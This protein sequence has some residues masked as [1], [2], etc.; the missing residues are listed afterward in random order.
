[1]QVD[2]AT[3]ATNKTGSF[4]YAELGIRTSRLILLVPKYSTGAASVDKNTSYSSASRII[5]PLNLE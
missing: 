5:P 4:I 1:M 3:E 2:Y